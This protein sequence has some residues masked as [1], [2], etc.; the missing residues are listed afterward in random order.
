MKQFNLNSDMA[1]GYGPWTMGDDEGLLNIVQTANIACGFHAG[2]HNIMAAVMKKAHVRGVSIGAHPGFYDLHGFGRRQMR[3][4]D[5]EIENLM[6]YQIGAACAMASL[7]G[8]SVTHVKPH[9]ALNNM[10]CADRDMANA[11]TR[12]HKAVAPEL[13]LLAPALSEL[14]KSGQDAGLPTAI[15]VFADRSYM[16]DGQLTPRSR[17]DA[18][19]HDADTALNNCLQMIDN[20]EIQAVNGSILKIEAHSICV[21]GDEPTALAM[22]QY[23]FDGMVKAGFNAATLPQM[24]P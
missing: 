24:L 14:A 15:E 17:P 3:L 11:I 10:A 19:I 23:V 22:A 1:E 18:M 12:A 4:S 9:G 8:A 21:H 13:I 5:H 7:V 2:D 6:A 20:G 16:P